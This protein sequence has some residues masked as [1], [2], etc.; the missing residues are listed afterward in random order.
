MTMLALPTD[1]LNYGAL[2]AAMIVLLIAMTILF[3]VLWWA[4]DVMDLVLERVQHNTAALVRLAER[5]HGEDD[6]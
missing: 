2:G 5:L 4:R 6:V 3:R 1:V